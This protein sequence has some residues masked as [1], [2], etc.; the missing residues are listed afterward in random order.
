MGRFFSICLAGAVGTG[1]R[2]LLGLWADRAFGKTLP[3]GTL[4]VNVIGCFLIAL[5]GA[6]ALRT[7]FVSPSL[8]LV[9]STGFL[10]GLTTYSSFNYDTTRLLTSSTPHLGVLYLLLTLGLCG[11]AGVL[12]L[13]LARLV[14]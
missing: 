5:V 14:A 6:L 7:T 10:G 3:F 2:Y 4:L 9:L 13:S 1:L 12:G 11:G 8:R